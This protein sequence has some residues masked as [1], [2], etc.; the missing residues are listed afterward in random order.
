MRLSIPSVISALQALLKFPR[1]LLWKVIRIFIGWTRFPPPQRPPS[2]SYSPYSPHDYGGISSPRNLFP[3]DRQLSPGPSRSAGAHC[4][5]TSRHLDYQAPPQSNQPQPSTL[6]STK[7]TLQV[8]PNALVTKPGTYTQQSPLPS[9]TAAPQVIEPYEEDASLRL[10]GRHDRGLRGHFQQSENLP[11]APVTQSVA[12]TQSPLPSITAASQVIE[13]HEEDASLHLES[14]RSRRRS[15]QSENLPDA[16]VTQP[17]TCTQ[18]PL[19]SIIAAPQV[20]EPHEE[21]ASLRLEGR[22]K[23]R[24][25]RRLQQSENLPDAPVAQSVACTQSPCPSI[26]TAPLVTEPSDVL[27]EATVTQPVAC[28][29][30][31]PHP[32]ITTAPLVVEPHENDVSPRLEG[33]RE[34]NRTRRHVQ[35]NENLAPDAPATQP[36][37]CTQQPRRPAIPVAPE[38][39]VELLVIVPHEDHESLRLKARHERHKMRKCLRKGE[40]AKASNQKKLAEKLILNA[41]MHRKNMVLLNKEASAK[42]FQEKNQ[43]R[44]RNIIDLH[45][46]HVPEAESHFKEAVEAARERGKSSLFVIVGKGIHS[47]GGIPKIK[48]TIC[49]LGE[50]LGMTVN[51]DPRNDGCLVV[52]FK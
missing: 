25:R 34:R 13:P 19:P 38:V 14:R 42:I 12:C 35:Q 52:N 31:P 39:V 44:K 36:V 41:E 18:S 8:P 3:T 37:T 51:V 11:D 5:T 50:R 17:V 33:R 10:E 4:S 21:N 7:T 40:Q 23:R 48:P 29:Q 16:L 30:Q 22:H 32:S 47:N 46:L 6:Y 27:P 28:T 1:W 45:R 49:A 2:D 24:S 43:K 20:I 15:Q 9:I 26:T